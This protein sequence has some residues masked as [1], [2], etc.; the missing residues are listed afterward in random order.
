MTLYESLINEYG[1]GNPFLFDEINYNNY[2]SP[3]IKKELNKLVVDN[4]IIRYER[5]MYYI[6]EKTLF[7]NSSLN[8]QKV[9]EKKYLSNNSGYY[10][11]LSFA[12]KVGITTQMPNTLEIYTNNEKSRVREIAVN[13]IKVIL[14]KSRVNITDDNVYVLSFLEFMNSFSK[15][16]FDD[17]RKKI[18]INYIKEKGINRSQITKYAPYYPDKVMR[19]LIESEIIYEIAQ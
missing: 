5:G 19:N 14:R 18:I 6:P 15:D 2:S 8:P 17:E 11:G 1:Y 7:G 9:I 4:K 13:N 3:W 10:S 12:N 16:Y